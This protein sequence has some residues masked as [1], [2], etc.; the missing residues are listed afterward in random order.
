MSNESESIIPVDEENPHQT[1]LIVMLAQR[2]LMKTR[3]RLGLATTVYNQIASNSSADLTKAILEY[4][5]MYL[6][7]C[8]LYSWH[9]KKME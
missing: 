8:Y 2:M 4:I 6:H 3:E 9:V 5:G 1:A 7:Y